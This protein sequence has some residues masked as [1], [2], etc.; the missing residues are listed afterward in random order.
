MI[1]EALEKDVA[2]LRKRGFNLSIFENGPTIYLQF[3]NF[4]LP[5][6]RYNLERTDLLIFTSVHYPYAG[7]DMFWTNPQLTLSDGTI[8]KQAESIENHLNKEWRRFSYH[9]YTNTPWNP[10]EDNVE[11]YVEYVQQRLRNGN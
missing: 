1:P 11:R 6:G 7:F 4:P 8:P 9:P 3:S 10:S 2:T 5:S